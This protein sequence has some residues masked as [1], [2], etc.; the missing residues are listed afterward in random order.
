MALN[1]SQIRAV[2]RALIS[3][4]GK[5]NVNYYPIK[6]LF[7]ISLNEPNPAERIKQLKRIR[8]SLKDYGAVYN[9]P[10]NGTGAVVCQPISIECKAIE[11][12]NSPDLTAVNI[13]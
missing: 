9:V 11:A 10:A 3:G 5:D 8:D 12:S 7:R 13:S 4:Y 2:E 6:K 1:A